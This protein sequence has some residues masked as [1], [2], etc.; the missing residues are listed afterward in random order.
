M[1]ANKR[2]K[3]YIYAHVVNVAL[4]SC[5]ILTDGKMNWPSG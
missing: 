1:P 2:H 3:P 4:S 5:K